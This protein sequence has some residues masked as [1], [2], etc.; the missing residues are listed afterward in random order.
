MSVLPPWLMLAGANVR[1]RRANH[2]ARIDA[3]VGVE[4]PV[5]DGLQRLRQ[6]R[7]HLLRREDDAVLAVRRENVADQQRLELR[8]RHGVARAVL[9]RMMRS[10][11]NSMC[12]SCSGT[13]SPS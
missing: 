6:K 1:E 8:D 9:E 7:G 13:L 12:R 11:R 5:L 10:F 2:R 4:A 3:E